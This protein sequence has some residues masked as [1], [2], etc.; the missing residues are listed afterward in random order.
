MIFNTWD[1][2]L[3]FLIPSAILCRAASPRLRPWVIFISGGLFFTYFSYTQFGGIAGAACLAIFLWETLVSRFYKPSSWICW[4]GVTQTVLFLA[5]F[6]YR[7]FLT[8]LFWHDAAHN[9]LYWKDAFLPLGI[10]FFTFEFVHYAVDRYKNKTEEGS[11]TEYLAFILFFPTMVAGPIKRYQDFLP[12]LRS[13][14]REWVVDWQRG[15]TRILTGLVKKFAVADVLTA[16]TNHLNWMDISRAQRTILPLWLFAYGIKIYADFSAYSD[17][18]IGSARLFGI[19]VPENF[20]WPYLRTNITDFWRHWHMSLTNW[21]IDYIYIPL[22]GSRGRSGQ[23][24]ANILVT[25]L[26]S[27]IW[28]GAGFNFVLW[29]LLHGIMLAIRRG[30]RQIRPMPAG[31]PHV[32]SQMGSWLLTYVAVNLA[33]AFFCMDVHTALFFFRRL[34][35]G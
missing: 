17:I 2:Y 34:L 24:Y 13:I 29:G 10:S 12:K 18:A 35:I 25:M 4:F 15:L 33:W 5:L 26:V 14:S 31:T 23:V 7:N 22:G 9:P 30:W 6:K 20:D 8:G 11:A 28:H 16:Y 19:R 3:L 27:G 21:L 32:W 1:Y